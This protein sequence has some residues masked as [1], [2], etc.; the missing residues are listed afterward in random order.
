M[1]GATSQK[2]E[3]YGLKKT[4]APIL[5]LIYGVYWFAAQTGMLHDHAHGHEH[6]HVLHDQTAESDPC[7][8]SIYHGD[9]SHGCKH[10]AHLI[11]DRKSCELCDAVRNHQASLVEIPQLFLTSSFYSTPIAFEFEISK[12]DQPIPSNKGPPFI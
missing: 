6:E 1:Q 10:D 7:H 5:L 9:K 3:P 2:R 12:F 8:R 11:K 4:A